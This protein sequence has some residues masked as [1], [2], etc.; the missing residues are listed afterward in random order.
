MLKI[1]SCEYLLYIF[2][3]GFFFLI[4][5]IV[6]IIN[7][8]YPVTQILPLSSRNLNLHLSYADAIQLVYT[9]QSEWRSSLMSFFSSWTPDFSY[10]IFYI[11][12]EYALPTFTSALL[13][14]L[15]CLIMFFYEFPYFKHWSN[16]VQQFSCRYFGRG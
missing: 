11:L 10:S 3:F 4:S 1:W 13:S 14:V 7:I 2:F 9:K 16:I 6:E 8:L 12:F 15:W 5:I